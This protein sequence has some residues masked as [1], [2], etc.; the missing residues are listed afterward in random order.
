MRRV[1]VT[2][3]LTIALAAM[4]AIYNSAYA[5]QPKPAFLFRTVVSSGSTIA[6]RVLNPDG[7]FGGAAISDNG[8]LAFVTTWHSPDGKGQGVSLFTTQPERVVAT[9]GDI[10]GGRTLLVVAGH[11]IAVNNA[12]H[13]AFI[14]YCRDS[15]GAEGMSLFV[16]HDFVSAIDAKL[17]PTLSTLTLTDDGRVLSQDGDLLSPVA[18][19]TP[20]LA[21]RR[22][23]LKAQQHCPS[24]VFPKPREWE[25][26]A[27]MARPIYSEAFQGLP[28]TPYDSPV[29]GHIGY[30]YRFIFSAKGCAPSIIIVGDVRAHSHW[31]M[32]T[33]SGFLGWARPNGAVVF[34]GFDKNA[35]LNGT[36]PGTQMF[37]RITSRGQV[38]LPVL[39]QPG[40]ALLLATPIAH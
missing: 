11:L 34:N 6:G 3:I 28:S 27:G 31:E 4:P 23:L 26:G 14:A 20:A 29:L 13:V 7:Y 22:A 36:V 8:S 25:T 33:P 10:I 12:G 19:D 37:L 18:A 35:V 17:T 38:L 39:F 5:Q 32:W 15:K 21:E 16:D 9:I 24:P 2:S 40:F 1:R 30:S